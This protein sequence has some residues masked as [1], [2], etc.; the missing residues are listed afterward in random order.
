[1]QFRQVCKTLGVS[2][3][4]VFSKAVKDFLTEHEELI[5]ETTE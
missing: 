5:E 2:Y 3:N 4:S 1:M